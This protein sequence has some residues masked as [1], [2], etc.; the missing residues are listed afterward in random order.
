MEALSLL[1]LVLPGY[2]LGRAAV[3]FIRWFFSE[4]ESATGFVVRLLL[5]LLLLQ[6]WT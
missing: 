2:I 4:P 1:G 5:G 6:A 3:K